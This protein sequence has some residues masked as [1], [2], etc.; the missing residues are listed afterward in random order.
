MK[1]LYHN[2][3]LFASILLLFTSCGCENEKVEPRQ[4]DTLLMQMQANEG[5][6]AKVKS[7]FGSG[8]ASDWLSHSVSLSGRVR[9]RAR[10][11][12]TVRVIA[13]VL[14]ALYSVVCFYFYT[15]HEAHMRP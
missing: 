4:C 2:I 13:L 1:T 8:P 10:V 9:V 7:E 3:I 12:F 15:G 14:H 5:V 11:I 6:R